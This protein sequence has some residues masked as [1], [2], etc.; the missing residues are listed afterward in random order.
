MFKYHIRRWMGD[1]T[2]E[3]Q[4]IR[5]PVP[6]DTLGYYYRIQTDWDCLYIEELDDSGKEIGM[7]SVSKRKPA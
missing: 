3:D 5:S 6:I 4:T 7:Y 2:I 1:I